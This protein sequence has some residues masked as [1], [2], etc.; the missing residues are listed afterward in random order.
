MPMGTA[1]CVVRTTDGMSRNSVRTE[2]DWEWRLR[3]DQFDRIIAGRTVQV[4]K[5]AM[6]EWT[7]QITRIRVPALSQY[8]GLCLNPCSGLNSIKTSKGSERDAGKA[9]S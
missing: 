2:S 5:C 3:K 4:R 9:L 8:P 1:C 6:R 7:L